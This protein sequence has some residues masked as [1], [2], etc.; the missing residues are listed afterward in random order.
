VGQLEPGAAPE[1][2]A[3]LAACFQAMDAS[4]FGTFL[5]IS[6]MT[7]LYN[8]LNSRKTLIEYQ[9]CPNMDRS[10]PKFSATL[11]T[12]LNELVIA[13]NVLSNIMEMLLTALTMLSTLAKVCLELSSAYWI[14]R[15]SVSSL[16]VKP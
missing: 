9:M 12:A 6:H 14:K 3:P 11:S 7:F 15:L 8:Q 10:R 13:K 4:L 16:G 1:G 5:P 2:G